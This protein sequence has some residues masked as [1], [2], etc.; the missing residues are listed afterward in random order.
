MLFI[1]GFFTNIKYLTISIHTWYKLSIVLPFHIWQQCENYLL[2]KKFYL[3]PNN[4]N[5]VMLSNHVHIHILIYIY[6]YISTYRKI[7]LLSTICVDLAFRG[8][9]WDYLVKSMRI[10][11]HIICLIKKSCTHF[12]ET[13]S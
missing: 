13:M 2:I 5:L 4:K 11:F 10:Y 1:H 9:F 12:I 7:L 6:T 3:F 8:H